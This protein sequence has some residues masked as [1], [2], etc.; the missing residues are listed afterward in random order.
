MKLCVG[1]IYPWS[2]DRAVDIWAAYRD[3][4]EAEQAEHP[5]TTLVWW[6]IPLVTAAQD[7]SG[8]NAEKAAFN[9]AVRDYC[10]ANGCVLFDI[11]DIESHDPSGNPVMDAS[12]NEACWS[13]YVTDGAHLNETG[14]Q[15]LA[16]AI[17]WLL[18][19]VAGWNGPTDAVPSVALQ[20]L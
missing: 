13:G 19:R 9:Q 8:G 11:A 12:G 7:P 20:R 6:T 14:R 4:M 3:M 16:S 10:A 15:R 5:G 2:S 1:D 18:A 17:W